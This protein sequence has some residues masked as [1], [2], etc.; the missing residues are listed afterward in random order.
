MTSM[1]ILDQS[2]IDINETV[3]DGI[4]RTVE[5]AQLADKLKYT[6]Y[7]VAE[8]HNIPEVAGTSPEILVTHLLNKTN[9]I[10]IGSGGVM[11][12][13][14]SP[15]KVIEQFHFISY[16]APGRVDLGIGKAPGGFPL[17]TQA[18]QSEFKSPQVTFN[19]KFQLLNNFNN[20]SFKEDDAYNQLQ[21]SIRDSDVPTPELFL[22]GG[23][24]HSAQFA[25]KENVGFVYAFFINSNVDILR[26][27]VKSY[28][29]QYPEGRFIVAVAAVV[30]ENENEKALVEE[31]RTN[32]ALHF[33]DGRKITVNTKEQLEEFSKQSAEHFEVE[34]KQIDVLEGSAAEVK[35]Q[36]SQ[37]NNEGL[38]D[39]FMLHMPIQNHK[40][41]VKTVEQLAPSYT[42]ANQKEGV[43]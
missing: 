42:I 19:D 17:A 24:D 26:S 18:L 14:Y 16:L 36:L 2:P 27:A 37:L 43:L 31:G 4:Q 22:L 21:T 34:E 25:A 11:L 1:S 13:H 5:L 29:Q 35:H 12:Q 20:R 10:R 32:Y 41:R 28:K 6:R 33:K 23:S 3:N 40:L 39:E 15:F 7:F 8:H 38:I 9:E 30:T